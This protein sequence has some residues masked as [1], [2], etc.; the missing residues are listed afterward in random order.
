MRKGT[1][2]GYAM[3]LFSKIKKHHGYFVRGSTV[4]DG[5]DYMYRTV[6]DDE[7]DLDAFIDEVKPSKS[8]RNMDA[9]VLTLWFSMP[10]PKCEG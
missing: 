10:D 8:T 7:D 3:D 1:T 9:G 6:W 5:V 4:C 2:V